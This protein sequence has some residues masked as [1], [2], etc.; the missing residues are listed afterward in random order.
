MQLRTVK[1]PKN[2]AFDFGRDTPSEQPSGRKTSFS[3]D[4]GDKD[5]GNSSGEVRYRKILI[6]L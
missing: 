4:Q 2:K 5:G 3:K 1:K 6:F